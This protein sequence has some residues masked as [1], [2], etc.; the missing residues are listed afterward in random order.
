VVGAVTR[1]VQLAAR[2]YLATSCWYCLGLVI[3]TLVLLAKNP[4][5]G[6]GIVEAVAVIVG[7]NILI[8]WLSSRALTKSRAAGH[9]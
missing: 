6:A 9:V 8:I 1:R 5:F 4:S 2:V 3:A 7:A